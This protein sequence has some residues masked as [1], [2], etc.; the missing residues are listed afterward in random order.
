M[1]GPPTP[2][3]LSCAPRRPATPPS[4]PPH[5]FRT[6]GHSSSLAP[7]CSGVPA[8]GA[9]RWPCAPRPRVRA[10]PAA[11]GV[12]CPAGAWYACGARSW[13]DLCL[14]GPQLP[15]EADLPLMARKADPTR[16]R[17]LIVRRSRL[18]RQPWPLP[19]E[20]V[21]TSAR[22]HLWPPPVQLLSQLAH[23]AAACLVHLWLQCR[24]WRT[25]SS[26]SPP[27]SRSRCQPSTPPWC[28]C[29]LLTF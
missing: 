8:G 17:A 28:R 15:L 11:E 9:W 14:R 27:P 6:A 24:L 20:S 21:R 23:A 18:H 12:F 25:P 1:L 7:S 16:P 26:S 13:C 2:T 29:G 3:P 5:Q 22:Y 4:V 19:F 10:P